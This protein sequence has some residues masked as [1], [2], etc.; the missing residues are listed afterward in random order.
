MMSNFSHKVIML[1]NLALRVILLNEVIYEIGRVH[2]LLLRSATVLSFKI[3]KWI[4]LLPLAT[5]RVL[6]LKASSSGI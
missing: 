3:N 1:M 4:I 2:D 6:V 5:L